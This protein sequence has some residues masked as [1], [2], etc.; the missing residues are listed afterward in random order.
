MPECLAL[1]VV[2]LD[3]GV[4]MSDSKLRACD[5]TVKVSP[6]RAFSQRTSQQKVWK[7]PRSGKPRKD[8]GCGS[9]DTGETRCKG[10]TT[11]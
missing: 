4:S 8:L 3:V 7:D 11:T 6:D 9:Q 1:D 10:L 2:C 5:L